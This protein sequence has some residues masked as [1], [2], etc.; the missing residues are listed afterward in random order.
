MA[1]RLREPP[2]PAEREKHFCAIKQPRDCISNDHRTNVEP[3]REANTKS[4][5]KHQ[6]S[7]KTRS[8][9]LGGRSVSLE[10]AATPKLRSGENRIDVDVRCCEYTIWQK[11]RG[12][13]G[14]LDESAF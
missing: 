3:T 4:S 12:K 8:R 11:E 13:N 6:D 5:E 2:C 1:L 10:A 14:N 7:G 9:E